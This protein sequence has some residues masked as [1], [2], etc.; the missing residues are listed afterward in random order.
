MNNVSKVPSRDEISVIGSVRPPKVASGGGLSAIRSPIEKD[1]P[2]QKGNVRFNDATAA[3]TYNIC[4]SGETIKRYDL[5]TY[6]FIQFSYHNNSL[7]FFLFKNKEDCLSG[8]VATLLP[9]KKRDVYTATITR[10][11]NEEEF[12]S[13]HMIARLCAHNARI[14]RDILSSVC[15]DPTYRAIVFAISI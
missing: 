3:N 10:F 15:F 13:Q 2:F 8:P 11:V 14:N 5:D 7:L 1:I 4:F 12:S 9:S 6:R